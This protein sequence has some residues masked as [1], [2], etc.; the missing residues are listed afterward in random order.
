M[1][2]RITPM[3]I[4]ALADPKEYAKGMKFYEAGR[5]KSLIRTNTGLL[6]IVKADENCRV[7]IVVDGE[8]FFGN[9]TCSP[10]SGSMCRHQVA[11]A[12][13]FLEKPKAFLPFD[14]LRK[15]IRKID[16]ATLVDL[17]TNL[18]YVIPDIKSFF[19]T[20][21][22]ETEVELI[23]RQVF[24]VF[25]VQQNG[26]WQVSDITFPAMIIMQRARMFRS[27]G[28]WDEARAIFF[29][30]LDKALEL[31]DKKHGAAGYPESFLPTLY[32]AYEGAAMHDPDLDVKREQIVSEVELLQAHESTEMEGIYFDQLV[33]M[34]ER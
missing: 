30:L 8:Q 19:P 6:A 11:V 23:T 33:E 3:D 34:L 18:V 25:D 1:P 28:R 21:D 14:T 9:C 20:T 2:T 24:E 32:D 5:V 27:A 31:D 22:D 15:A 29:A 17:L 13:H 26:R 16:K 7:E 12:L 4:Q 10:A